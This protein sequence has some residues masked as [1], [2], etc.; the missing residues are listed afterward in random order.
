MEAIPDFSWS[1]VKLPIWLLTLLLAITY[2][3]SVQMG[4]A[5]PFQ[6]SMFQKLSNDIRNPIIQWVLTPEI[7]LWKFESLVRLQFPKW[8]LI[9]ECEDSFPHTLLHSRA[10]SLGWHPRKPLLWSWTQGYKWE[11][12]WECE[13]SYPHTLLHSQASSFGWHPCKPLP[14]SWTQGYKWEFTWECKRVWG[15]EPSHSLTLP[16][17]FFWLAPSQALALVKSPRLWLWQFHWHSKRLW[18]FTT[19]EIV[20]KWLTCGHSI[21]TSWQVRCTPQKNLSKCKNHLTLTQSQLL[22]G[23]KCESWTKNNGRARSWGTFHGS[24]HFGKVEGHVGVPGWD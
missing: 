12:T 10:F 18:P 17:F 6:I 19:F 20:S 3:L 21:L 22:E 4:Y 24:Q 13:G 1:G 11:L 15:N 16:N 23:F 2:V 9:W 14:W 5:S 7:V 8:E